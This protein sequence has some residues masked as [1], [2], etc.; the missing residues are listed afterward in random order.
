MNPLFW[1]DRK[2]FL[3]GHTGFKGSWLSLWLQILGAKTTGYAL[4]PKTTPSIFE[5]A[6]VAQGMNSIIGDIRDGKALV[7]CLNVHLP[8]I[9][10]HLAAQPL[11]RQ[12]YVDPLETYSTNV[13]GTV[14]LLE[15][16]RK[17]PSVRAV[18]IVTSDKCYENKEWEW[19][20]RETE[21]MGGLDPYSSSKGCA[22]LIVAA[23]RASFFNFNGFT[24]N[25]VG[26]ATA[27]AGNVIGGGD[28]A[29]DRLVPDLLSAFQ[30]GQPAII[31]FPQSTRPWQH[32][33]EPL[34]GYMLLAQKLYIDGP[35]YANSWN[36]GPSEEESCKVQWIADKFTQLWGNGAKW[37]DATSGTNPHEAIKLKLDSSRAKHALGWKPKWSLNQAIEN[38]VMWHKGYIAGNDMRAMTIRQIEEYSISKPENSV[39]FHI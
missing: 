6:K 25:Y 28:W 8:E 21:P 24:N 39:G 7:D 23:Y 2:V 1:K 22:E 19:G 13:M 10:I 26:I 27:R 3:T 38:I 32:V 4:N 11:V 15:A 20:Y 16:V 14:N 12:S 36:F 31:R 5:V 37:I 29:Q 34:N 35:S 30:I 18:V 17:T 9:V 33:I